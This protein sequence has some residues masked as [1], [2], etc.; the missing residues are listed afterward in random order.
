MPW[1][2][3]G[4]I[5]GGGSKLGS[6]KG[7]KSKFNRSLLGVSVSKQLLDPTTS[8]IRAWKMGFSSTC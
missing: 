4:A 6:N 1:I 3:A 7:S 5:L 8:A 2:F